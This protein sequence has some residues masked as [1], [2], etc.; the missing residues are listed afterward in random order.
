MRNTPLKKFAKSAL[1]Q[2][3]V[4]TS[5][6]SDDGGGTAEINPATQAIDR[7]N[8]MDQLQL[9]SVNK[10]RIRKGLDPLTRLV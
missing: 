10:E 3:M 8:K 4:P 1:K 9:N 5:G 2:V 6:P 7:L